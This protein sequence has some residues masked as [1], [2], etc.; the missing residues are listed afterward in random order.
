MTIELFYVEGCPH[1][2]PARQL[3]RRCLAALG[4]DTEIRERVGD[5]PSPTIR[6]NG[7]DVMGAP[8]CERSSCR[9]DVPTEERVLAALRRAQGGQP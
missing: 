7:E 3:L 1:A 9:L 5:L 8:A 6:V 4:L 2:A